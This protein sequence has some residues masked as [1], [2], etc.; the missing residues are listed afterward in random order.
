MHRVFVGPGIDHGRWQYAIEVRGRKYRI[1][2]AFVAEKVAVELDGAAFH[3]SIEQ[4]ERD[5]RRDAA[6][7][8]IGWL[9]LRF[10][11]ERLH[12]DVAGVR[13]DV[14]GVLAGRKP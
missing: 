9:T 14:R 5:L 2:L 8:S 13:R 1:D 10:S 12:R 6:L 3:G 7:A 11:Y 4:R